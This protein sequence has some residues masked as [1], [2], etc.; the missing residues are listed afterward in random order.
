MRLFG[1]D[2][3]RNHYA[4]P[5]WSLFAAAFVV[6]PLSYAVGYGLIEVL[7]WV[8]LTTIQKSGGF[9]HVARLFTGMCVMAIPA[10]I[11]NAWFDDASPKIL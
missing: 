11:A 7:G 10:M 5:I 6:L 8:E 2:I 4:L 9:L 1:F 3:E